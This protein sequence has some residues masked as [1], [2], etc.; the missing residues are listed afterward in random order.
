MKLP[1]MVC[2]EIFQSA[3]VNQYGVRNNPTF[4]RRPFMRDTNITRRVVNLFVLRV[5]SEDP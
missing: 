1:L 2:L 5:K 4:I 3:W